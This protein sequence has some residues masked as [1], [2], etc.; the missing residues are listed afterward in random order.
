MPPIKGLPAPLQSLVEKV[1]GPVTSAQIDVYG[2]WQ[3]IEN[4]K[5]RVRT[6]LTAWKH[7]QT[8]DREL[9]SH[10]AA[11]LLAALA[12]QALVI[13]VIFILIGCGVLTFEPWTANAFIMG[14]FAEIG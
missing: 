13:N 14:V 11:Y 6:V 3:E 8:Q 4:A 2:R 5:Y 7:Q 10:Y 1:G 12:V 9:R